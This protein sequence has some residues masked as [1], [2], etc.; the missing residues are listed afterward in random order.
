MALRENL[1]RLVSIIEEGPNFD[2][3]E[4]KELIVDASEDDIRASSKQFIQ[5]CHVLTEAL[6]RTKRSVSG[7]HLIGTAIIKFQQHRYQLT[8]IHSDFCLLCLDAKCLNPALAFLENDY[9]EI[10]KTD[11]KDDDVKRVMLFYYYGG[12][13]YTAIKNFDRATFYFEVVLT[14]PATVVSP[15]VQETYKKFLIL[16]VL[17]EGKLQDNILPKYTSQCITRHKKAIASPHYYKFAQEYASLNYEQ[18]SRLV[19]T[20]N[21]QF[22]RDE[23]M[24]LI[25]QCLTQV[26]RRNIQRLTKTFLTLPLRDVATYVGLASEKEAEI[27][28]LNM[29]D[30]GEISATINQKDGMVIFRDNTEKY[31]SVSVFQGLQDDMAT[32]MTLIKTL[33]KMEMDNAAGEPG[34]L[35]KPISDV[36]FQQAQR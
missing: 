18:I 31:D 34:V 29:I 33:K 19:N 30:D 7:I 12:L 8:P 20:Y 9:T 27:Y 13:I 3:E 36:C 14:V 32:T 26:H 16:K 15:I 24:G 2:L 5:F 10:R 35:T 22:E 4:I 11:D 23:N 6:V 21:A 1:S 17:L 25:K 28:I